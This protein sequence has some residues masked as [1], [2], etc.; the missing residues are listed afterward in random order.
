VSWGRN[1]GALGGCNGAQAAFS[2]E[3]GDPEPEPQAVNSRRLT[4]AAHS[5]EVVL[6]EFTT[7]RGGYPN[8]V[9][10]TAA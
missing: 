3:G 9:L 6:R 2:E 5:S 10:Q 4:T 7:L 1:P 8:A